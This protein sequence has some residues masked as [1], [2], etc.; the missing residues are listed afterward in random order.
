MN[1]K[2]K[3]MAALLSA[4]LLLL[5][6]PAAFAAEYGEANITPQTT[7]GEIRSNPSIVG[8]GLW[9]YAKEQKLQS[10]ENLLNGQTLEKYVGSWVAQ[11]CADGLNLLM[12]D[13]FSFD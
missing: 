12:P 5:L 7:M 10:A 1:V 8:S 13:T 6:L 9:T 11:D 4:C 2:R 3:I